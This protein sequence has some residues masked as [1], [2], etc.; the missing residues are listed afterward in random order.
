MPWSQS[1]LATVYISPIGSARARSAHRE[2]HLDHDAPEAVQCL[3]GEHDRVRRPHTARLALRRHCRTRR[4]YIA[5][6]GSEGD[7]RAPAHS[8]S[9]TMHRGA[10]AQAAAQASS[11]IMIYRLGACNLEQRL[12][13]AGEHGWVDHGRRV[14]P[15]EQYSRRLFSDRCRL[16]SA[17]AAGGR[18][19]ARCAPCHSLA[20]PCT[21]PG[22]PRNM[23]TVH[24]VDPR[25]VLE[26]GVI[27]GPGAHGQ[28]HGPGHHRLRRLAVRM[29][30]WLCLQTS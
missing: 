27:L 18:G 9:S 7:I 6:T 13:L 14:L 29:C 30:A 16:S 21:P 24:A 23:F 12:A 22:Q 15:S 25:R 17:S 10:W 28:H 11:A 2:A 26:G 20:A 4:R 8:S 19:A 3:D 5:A 1:G